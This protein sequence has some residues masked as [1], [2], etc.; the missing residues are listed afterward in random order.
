MQDPAVL[1][2]PHRL[3]RLGVAE[4]EDVCHPHADAGERH[5]EQEGRMGDPVRERRDAGHVA[6]QD[7]LPGLDRVGAAG[8]TVPDD[9]LHLFDR[10]AHSTQR[11]IVR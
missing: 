5:V 4:L 6:Q 10:H 9:L 7:V 2:R 11:T 8:E 1:A 3:V